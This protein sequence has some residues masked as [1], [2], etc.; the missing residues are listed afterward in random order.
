MFSE[1]ISPLPFAK[2]LSSTLLPWIMGGMI[3]LVLALG[4]CIHLQRFSFAEHHR[5]T[6]SL[7]L[8]MAGS[9]AAQLKKARVF[10]RTVKQHPYVKTGTLIVKTPFK[11]NPKVTN[12]DMETRAFSHAT[13]I[14]LWVKPPLAN[15]ITSI[16]Q[17]AK[18]AGLEFHF[19]VHDTLAYGAQFFHDLFSV[20]LMFWLVLCGAC[21]ALAFF[22][23]IFIYFGTHKSTIR[24]LMLMGA[25]EGYVCRQIRPSITR[26][27]ARGFV[28]ATLFSSSALVALYVLR[29]RGYVLHQGLNVAFFSSFLFFAA[30]AITAIVLFAYV[31]VFWVVRRFFREFH[32]P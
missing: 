29:G 6:P 14:H 20:L 16:R 19:F 31:S 13:L 4:F 30:C 18:H 11:H 32:C 17:E 25:S 22:S 23:N 27:L 5:T 2:N 28:I 3:F 1:K 9:D 26:M 21:L 15:V 7:T 12:P 24:L 10:L 8:E